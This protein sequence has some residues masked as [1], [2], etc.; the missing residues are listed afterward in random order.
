LNKE[1]DKTDEADHEGIPLEEALPLLPSNTSVDGASHRGWF[2]VHFLES[3]CGLRSTS[4]VE[5]K[6]EAYHAGEERSWRGFSERA[7]TLCIIFK[8][9]ASPLTRGRL[10]HLVCCYPSSMEN[11]RGYARSHGTMALKTGSLPGASGLPV[12]LY[13]RKL[14]VFVVQS[15]RKHMSASTVCGLVRRQIPVS[16]GANRYCKSQ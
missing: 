11:T 12:P 9:R 4:A 8:G 13:N 1:S 7:T 16:I 3:V 15:R 14:N 5:V 10:H 2:I 6:W